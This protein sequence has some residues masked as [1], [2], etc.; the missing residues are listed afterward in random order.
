MPA[1]LTK[2]AAAVVQKNRALLFARGPVAR[3]IRVVAVRE[4]MKLVDHVI[5]AVVVRCH[6]GEPRERADRPP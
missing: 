3:R 4:I 1:R 2:P 6:G 5:E